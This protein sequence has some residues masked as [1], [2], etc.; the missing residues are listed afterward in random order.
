[1][2]GTSREVEEE[3]LSMNPERH[4]TSRLACQMPASEEWDGLV[5]R[6]P[7]FQM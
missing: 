6:I 1:V 4:P 2:V 5:V 7:E 3:M